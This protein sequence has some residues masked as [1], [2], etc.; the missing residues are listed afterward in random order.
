[1]SRVGKVPITVPKGA[2]VSWRAPLF[3]V[4]GPKGELTVEVNPPC[5]IEI[6]GEVV[7]VSRPDDSRQSRMFQGLYRSLVGNAVVGVTEGYV[8]K[9]DI[10]GV[11]YKAEVQGKVLKLSVGYAFPKEVP[12][13]EGLDVTMEKDTIVVSGVDKQQVGDLAAKIRNWRPPEPYKGKGVRYQG[14]YVRRKA[15]KSGVGGGAPGS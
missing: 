6:E 2:E 14:E 12:I 4:K 15:G 1:M 3:K 13:P 5:S 9:L 10:I 11:G 7:R 8:K